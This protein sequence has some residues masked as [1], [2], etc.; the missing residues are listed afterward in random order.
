MKVHLRNSKKVHVMFAEEVISFS[1]LVRRETV[2]IDEASS[3]VP[4]GELR[5]QSGPQVSNK[6][7]LK[8]I[9]SPSRD[10]V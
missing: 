8:L 2:T 10:C 4:A 7:V 5:S 9:A 1:M 3:T 6:Q